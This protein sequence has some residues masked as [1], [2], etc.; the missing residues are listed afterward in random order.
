MRAASPH[1]ADMCDESLEIQVLVGGSVDD[2][3]LGVRL[4]E[5]QSLWA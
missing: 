5:S 1:F 3:S 2:L 4:K